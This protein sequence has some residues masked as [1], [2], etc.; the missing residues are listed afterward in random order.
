MRKISTFIL[1]ILQLSYYK[2]DFVTSLD[3][4]TFSYSYICRFIEILQFKTSTFSVTVMNN[5]SLY[6]KNFKFHN[7]YI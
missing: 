1:I 2:Y 7:D 5:I 4:T 6:I 3:L